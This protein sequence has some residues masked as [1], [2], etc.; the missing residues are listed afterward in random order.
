MDFE[1]KKKILWKYQNEFLY[2]KVNRFKILNIE[3][4]FKFQ[5]LL[6][7]FQLYVCKIFW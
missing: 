6:N 7:N 2:K 4:S 1:K 5:H 3:Y